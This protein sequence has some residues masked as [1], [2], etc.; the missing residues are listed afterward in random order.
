MKRLVLTLCL[1]VALVSCKKETST[2][3]EVVTPEEMKEL[4]EMEDVQ[5][6]DVRTPEEYGEGFIDGFQN[7]DF[8][9]DTF[10]EDIQ[11][12]DKTKPVIVYCKSG[13]RSASCAQEMKE[14]GF[15]K[16]YDLE[17][18]ITKWKYKGYEVK[19]NP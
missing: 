16:I 19:T 2:E 4:A 17:G 9:S 1:A 3:I 13:G 14:N 7:I 6:V 10:Q 18:G 5:L 8:R 12:L 15:V 11:K